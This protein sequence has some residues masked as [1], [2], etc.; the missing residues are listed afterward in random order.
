MTTS[1]RFL[2]IALPAALVGSTSGYA[3][4]YLTIE[5][6]QKALFPGGE[7]KPVAITLSPAQRK[8]IAK[9]SGVRVR[10]A[11]LRVW[12]DAVSGGWL[13]VDEVVGKH[14]FITYA[15]AL[16]RDGA[17]TGIEIMDFRE[18]YGDEVKNDRW[19]AQFIGKTTN[20]A[21]KLDAD[22]KNITGATLS[23]ASITDGVRRL[24]ATHA[25]VLQRAPAP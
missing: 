2:A 16:T 10:E 18:S 3:V 24:L 1:T 7:L 9:V 6:V 21:L 19:R 14:E 12:C 23:C 20:A 25:L 5:Q 13:F 8:T 11:I 4:T 17:V 22:I 15:V